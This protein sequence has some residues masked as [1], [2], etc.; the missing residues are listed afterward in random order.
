MYAIK[1]LLLSYAAAGSLEFYFDLHAHANKKGVFA[2]G[3]ALEGEAHLQSL[4][5]CRLVAINSPVFD[6]W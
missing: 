2:Y 4:L 3:N 6:F 1:H 5:F